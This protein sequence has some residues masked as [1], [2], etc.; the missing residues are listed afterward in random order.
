MTSVLTYLNKCLSAALR[1]GGYLS[2]EV[3]TDIYL[4]VIFRVDELPRY[5]KLCRFY[6]LGSAWCWEMSAAEIEKRIHLVKSTFG[7]ED[8]TR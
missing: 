5:W 4:N 2:R 1:Y 8:D 3:E 6:G 7:E